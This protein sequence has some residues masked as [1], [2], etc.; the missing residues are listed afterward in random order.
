M[1]GGDPRHHADAAALLPVGMAAAALH[2]HLPLT[3]AVVGCPP[4]PASSGLPFSA[5]QPEPSSYQ[6][7][8][9]VPLGCHWCSHRQGQLQPGLH[10]QL[11][12]QLLLPLPSALL[13]ASDWPCLA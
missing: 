6:L 2:Q 11:L 5:M 8:P 4:P 13:C 3:P 7:E 1:A 9:L 10:Q 12:G